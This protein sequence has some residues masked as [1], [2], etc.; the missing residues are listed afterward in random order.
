MCESIKSSVQNNS[1]FRSA[2]VG[3]DHQLVLANIEL[4]LHCLQVMQAMENGCGK[5]GRSRVP[6]KLRG[7]SRVTVVRIDDLQ[8]EN[9]RNGHEDGQG[10]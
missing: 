4:K 9:E 2:D 10:E 7:E 1:S 6:E 3:S 5:A 8:I